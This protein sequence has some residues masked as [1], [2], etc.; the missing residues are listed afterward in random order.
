MPYN[1]IKAFRQLGISFDDI[2]SLGCCSIDGETELKLTP[3][4]T[5]EGGQ[6]RGRKTSNYRAWPEASARSDRKRS[7]SSAVTRLMIGNYRT[8]LFSR[9]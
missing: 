9:E 8:R 6:S 2:C 4:G 7:T 3:A 5:P 1:V